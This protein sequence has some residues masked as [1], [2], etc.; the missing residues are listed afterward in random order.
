MHSPYKQGLVIWL[1]LVGASFGVL[2]WQISA[3]WLLLLLGALNFAAFCLYGLDKFLAVRQAPRI[4]EYVLYLAAF[5]GGAVGALAAMQI[6]RHKTSKLSFKFALAMIILL[7]VIIFI[8]IVEPTLVTE[9][10]SNF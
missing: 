5:T 10:F 6:F 2:L 8:L 9:T 3:P 1:A 4:P 7:E